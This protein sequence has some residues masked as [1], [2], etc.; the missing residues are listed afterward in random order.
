MIKFTLRRDTITPDLRARISGVS[1]ARKAA[2]LRLISDSLANTAKGAFNNSSLRPTPWPNK[3]DGSIATLR[4][5]QLL[6]RSPR[7]VSATP[8]NAILGSDRHYAAVHQM[9]SKKKGIPARRYMPFI[10]QNPT[11]LAIKRGKEAIRVYLRRP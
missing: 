8:R 7:T 2:M 1:G 9:G 3:A 4:R 10:G 6:A 5:D 11:A